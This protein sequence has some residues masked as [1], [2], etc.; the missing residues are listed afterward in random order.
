MSVSYWLLLAAALALLCARPCLRRFLTRTCLAGRSRVWPLRVRRDGSLR[1]RG[2]RLRLYGVECGDRCEEL[3][4]KL[5]QSLTHSRVRWRVLA[6]D[7]DGTAA[8]LLCAD[9]RN[10][11][12]ELLRQGLLH[13]R[14]SGAR[15]L[16]ALQSQEQL[17]R[18][19]I[20]GCRTHRAVAGEWKPPPFPWWQG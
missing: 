3:R 13:V 4:A 8:I 2:F 19:A 6:I 11:A 12:A 9:G 18:S 15:R 17:K 14:G 5:T 20:D 1:A 7:R 10:V 16:R